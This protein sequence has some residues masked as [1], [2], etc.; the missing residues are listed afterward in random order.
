VTLRLQGAIQSKEWI[1]Q[2]LGRQV[3]Q[4]HLCVT[5]DQ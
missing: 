4:D 2:W 3:A 5:H 1:W